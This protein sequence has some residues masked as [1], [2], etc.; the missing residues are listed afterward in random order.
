MLRDVV[1]AASSARAASRAPWA[2]SAQF[3][4]SSR[5]S[6]ATTT[7]TWGDGSGIGASGG[8]A[9]SPGAGGGTTVG[10]PDGSVTGGLVTWGVVVVV[11]VDGSVGWVTVG[12]VVGAVVVVSAHAGAAAASV[13]ATA[14]AEAPPVVSQRRRVG[15]RPG[16][17]WRWRRIIRG[18]ARRGPLIHRIERD[19]SSIIRPLLHKGQQFGEGGDGGVGLDRVPRHLVVRAQNRAQAGSLRPEDVVVRAVADENGRRGI[20]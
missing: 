12:S 10:R 2:L 16:R 18:S 19:R 9:G 15:A 14:S 6:C 7:S 5:W 17:V 11:V 20:I 1:A 13:T 8:G 4:T 3:C